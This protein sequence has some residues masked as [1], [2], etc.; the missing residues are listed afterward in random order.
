MCCS[1]SGKKYG[2]LRLLSHTNGAFWCDLFL[3]ACIFYDRET[4]SAMF[5]PQKKGWSIT[6][7]SSEKNGL[8]SNPRSLRG[9]IYGKGKAVVGSELPPPPPQGF[10]MEKGCDAG[11]NSVETQVWKSF[12]EAGMLD[13]ASLARKDKEALIE[14]VAKLETEVSREENH[15]HFFFLN[16]LSSN[17]YAK[18]YFLGFLQQC[19]DFV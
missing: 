18:T 14:R 10:L 3:L 9:S 4:R 19:D 15:K 16:V 17:K 6:P 8:L 5:T 1:V 2:H 7:R 11:E 13:E 12:T